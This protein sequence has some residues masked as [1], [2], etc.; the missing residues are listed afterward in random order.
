M[1]ISV[2]RRRI[3]AQSGDLVQ[4][5]VMVDQCAQGGVENPFSPHFVDSG[6]LRFS[7]GQAAPLV[8]Q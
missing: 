6:L 4:A 2:G 5:L 7:E 3:A 1:G 8:P